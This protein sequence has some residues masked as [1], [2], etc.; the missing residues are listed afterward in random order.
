VKVH[1]K[2]DSGRIEDVLRLAI[3]GNKPDFRRA[4]RRE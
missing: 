4:L 2:I 1:V 3:K